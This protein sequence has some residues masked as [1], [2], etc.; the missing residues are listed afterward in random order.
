[1]CPRS[2][3]IGASTTTVDGVYP[4][5][6]ADEYTIGLND[7]PGCRYA[8]VARLNW[9]WSKENPP[10]IASTRPVQGSITT[11]APETS[12]NWRSRYCPSTGLLSLSNSGSA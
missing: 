12:G 10:T 11:I 7:D 8:C 1:P 5:S 9:L 4:L 2:I 3:S 6:S